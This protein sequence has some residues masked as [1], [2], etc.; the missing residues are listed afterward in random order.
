MCSSALLVC[1]TIRIQLISGLNSVSDCQWTSFLFLISGQWSIL[2]KQDCFFLVRNIRIFL[3]TKKVNFSLFPG[4]V[5]LPRVAWNPMPNSVIFCSTSLLLQ[6]AGPQDMSQGKKR[7][8]VNM[9]VCV[10]LSCSVVSNSL[11]LYQNLPSLTPIVLQPF[12]CWTV[13]NTWKYLPVLKQVS[14]LILWC[15]H[16]FVT[17]FFQSGRSILPGRSP[18]LAYLLKSYPLFRCSLNV[19]HWKA[20]PDWI[21]KKKNGYHLV[22]S[23]YVLGSLISYLI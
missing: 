16:A 15:S 1:Q 18:S 2:M 23:F 14:D 19:I 22:F 6:N 8:T 3:A 17:L 10:H 12:M 5:L 21:S 20:Y 4:P 7:Q 11:G 9:S 13:Q